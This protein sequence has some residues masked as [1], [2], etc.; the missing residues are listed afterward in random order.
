M[1]S[2]PRSE[3]G[4][5]G[6]E[7]LHACC[8]SK[9][10]RA[11][12]FVRCF[13]VRLKISVEF[14]RLHFFVRFCSAISLMSHS[15]GG[16]CAVFLSVKLNDAKQQAELVKA[17]LEEKGISAFL[18]CDSDDDSNSAIANEALSQS[19]LLVVFCSTQS[20][21]PS[22]A[23]AAAVQ[24]TTSSNEPEKQMHCIVMNQK[25]KK[26]KSSSSS[27]NSCTHFLWQMT[28]K[29]K[30]SQQDDDDDDDDAAK[31]FQPLL[32][33]LVDAIVKQLAE[34]SFIS[35]LEFLFPHNFFHDDVC[36]FSRLK[37]QASWLTLLLLFVMIPNPLNLIRLH[38][39]RFPLPIPLS[40][41]T[42]M[43]SCG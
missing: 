21:L 17:S 3:S 16:G 8:W 4:A 30:R 15:C 36:I 2:Q 40:G 39:N 12:K 11:A 20:L 33:E 9:G 18:C 28:K 32:S 31:T 13:L 5:F 26:T 24:S 1:N 34:V 6:L 27:A 19:S 42:T 7:F 25:K 41:A 38:H 23:V 35:L 37:E 43:F 22:A 14:F 29:R 10:M